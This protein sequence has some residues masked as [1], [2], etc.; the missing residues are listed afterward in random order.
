VTR[1]RERSFRAPK[2]KK[3]K[4]AG[5]G[6]ISGDGGKIGREL[7]ASLK[8]AITALEPVADDKAE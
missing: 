1:C 3:D 5:R 7:L 8:K 6:K 4:P 2:N